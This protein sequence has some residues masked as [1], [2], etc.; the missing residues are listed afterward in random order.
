MFIKNLFKELDAKLKG[1]Q[2]SDKAISSLNEEIASPA[3]THQS[4]KAESYDV[5]TFWDAPLFVDP[6]NVPLELSLSINML[7]FTCRCSSE[8]TVVPE[9]RF[10]G[11][12]SYKSSWVNVPEEHLVTNSG[13]L[14]TTFC[15]FNLT[16]LT[17]SS[18]A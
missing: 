9:E 4:A 11:N 12:S 16:I 18:I 7:F 13:Y 10:V 2:A 15:Y 6:Q 17:S 8:T 1:R 3:P 14:I 5:A